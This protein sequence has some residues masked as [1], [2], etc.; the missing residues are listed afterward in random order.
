MSPYSTLSE[1]DDRLVS[2][3]ESVTDE[4]TIAVNQ[5]SWSQV[6]HLLVGL[7]EIPLTLSIEYIQGTSQSIL[8]PHMA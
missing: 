5:A 1:N 2:Q 8:F 7:G 6:T 4:N 3:G